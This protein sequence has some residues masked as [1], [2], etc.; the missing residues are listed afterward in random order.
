MKNRFLPVIALSVLLQF[1][2]SSARAQVVINE[3]QY[4]DTGAAD[5]RE[6]VELFNAGGIAID[7]SGWSVG[8]RDNGTVNS[9]VVVPAATTLPPG[10]YWVI[11]NTGVL[12]VNQVVAGGFLENDSEQLELWN[13]A[14]G[15]STLVDGVVYEAYRGPTAGT[16]TTSYGTLSPAMATQVGP[17][18]WGTHQGV[19]VAGTPLRPLTSLAR[20]I[21]GIDSNNN[22]RDFGLRPGTPG[23]ANSSVI[24]SSFLA[25]NVDALADGTTISGF[26][27]SFVGARVITP[28]TATPGLNPRAIPAPPNSTKAIVAWDQ[29]GGGN[30]VVS[31]TIFNGSVRFDLHA[32]LNTAHMTVNSNAA[33][34]QF[35][36]SE[37]T[38][39]G[40]GSM[41][42]FAN[43]A[44]PTGE[45][46]LGTAVSQN[47]ASGVAW[48]YEKVGES[49][50]GLDD[51]SQRLMLI[52]ARTGGN[53]NSGAGPIEW[54]I[55]ATIDLDA[56]GSA[57]HLLSLAIDAA[58]NGTAVF[59][60]QTFLF[61]T[62]NTLLGEFYVSYRENTQ[63]GSVGV[64]ENLLSPATFAPVPEPSTFILAGLGVL[65]LLALRRRK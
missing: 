52:D 31:D 8:S 22:G 18:Y 43:L 45:L 5:D 16:G 12:N 14:F 30:A 58:G 62:T 65:A 59:D 4:D 36:G 1:T 19:D 32:Y 6:Y 34:V 48:Y 9:S 56:A 3:F 49:A 24:T 35:R 40:L 26:T 51:V 28:G 10:A 2:S 11:G 55:L 41:D 13:G 38:F 54:T 27:G 60:T 20:Y 25:P 64:P 29:S 15:T 57:W 44:D 21:N 63:L 61:T 46:G 47:G 50:L 17:G 37:Q 42:A 7:I 23:T 33:N 53:A 39:Y